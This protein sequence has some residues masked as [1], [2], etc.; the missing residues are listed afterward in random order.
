M[1]DRMNINQFEQHLD[2]WGAD[3]VL[4]PADMQAA[5]FAFAKTADGLA[6]LQAEQRLANVLF[7]QSTVSVTTDV[8]ADGFLVRLQ[9]I[10]LQYD[11]QQPFQVRILKPIQRFLHSLDIEM[12]PALLMSQAAMFLVVLGLGVMVGFGGQLEAKPENFAGTIENAVAE[13]DISEELF[14]AAGD[15]NQLDIAPEEGRE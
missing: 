14:L 4:W 1:V 5:G 2:T 12:S 9:E 11:Q 6:L 7:S 15:A 13:V 3:I 8:D 10:P